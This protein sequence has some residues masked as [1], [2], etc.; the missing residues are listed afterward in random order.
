MIERDR[1]LLA[2][3]ARVN[4]GMGRATIQLMDNLHDGYLPAC[5]LR[6]LSEVLRCLAADMTERADE[7]EG[8]SLDARRV[9]DA[10]P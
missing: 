2:F 3:L 8:S 6:E 9:I 1:E 4:A 10:H 5:Q 7:L